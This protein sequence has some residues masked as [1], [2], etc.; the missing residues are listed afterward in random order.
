MWNVVK[1]KDGVR[2]KE[3]LLEDVVEQIGWHNRRVREKWIGV[4]AA[5]EV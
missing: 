1:I 5:V 4:R 2:E 3:A